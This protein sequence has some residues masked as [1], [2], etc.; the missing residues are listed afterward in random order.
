MVI[1]DVHPLATSL[2]TASSS[3]GSPS[4]LTISAR[5]VDTLKIEEVRFKVIYG[6]GTSQTYT[7][8]NGTEDG[9]RYEVMTED[10]ENGEYCYHIEAVNENRQ[11]IKFPS[12]GGQICFELTGMSQHWRIPFP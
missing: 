1:T 4:I 6:G 7:I 8:T 9:F 12:D 10:P 5:V 3:D 2:V 11:R